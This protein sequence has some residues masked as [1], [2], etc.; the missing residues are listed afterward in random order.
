MYSQTDKETVLKKIN[1]Y[2][3]KGKISYFIQKDL[4]YEW[5][6][7][8]NDQKYYKGIDTFHFNSSVAKY[9]NSPNLIKGCAEV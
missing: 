2:G 8:I 4:R 9:L 7:T 3:V 1:E 5:V 6:T